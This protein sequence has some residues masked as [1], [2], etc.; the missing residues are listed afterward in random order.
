MRICA[1]APQLASALADMGHEVAAFWPSEPLFDLHGALAAR[2]FEPELIIQQESLGQ[3]VLLTGMERF[4]CPKVFWSLDT[5]LNL[6]WQRHY[7]RL[8]DGVLSPHLSI[9]EREGLAGRLADSK[10]GRL[11]DSKA[12][13][14][15][16]RMAMFAPDRP[17]RPHAERPRA[18]G[19]VG[20]LTAFRPARRWLT[21][22]LRER[23]GTE[24]A[25]DLSFEAMLDHY[26]DTRLAP[27]ESLLGEVNFRLMEAAGCGCLVLNQDVG[28]DQD[29]LLRPGVEMEVCAH[30]L[31]LR[32][33]LDH[34]LS[35]PE[36]AERMARA[37]WE[38]IQ[39]EH[40]ARHR[41]QELLSFVSGRT[42]HAQRG[43]GAQTAFW[44]AL[45]GLARAGMIAAEAEALERSLA[46]LQPGAQALAARLTLACER[47]GREAALALAATALADP[48]LGPEPEVA[49]AGSMLGVLLEDWTVA[50]GFWLLR[51]RAA[52]N[53][54]APLPEHPAA[55]CVAWA[56]ELARAGRVGSG[57]FPYD[58]AEHVP[59][60]ALECLYLAARLAPEDLDVTRRLAAMT[61]GMRGHDY[62][63]MAHLSH[64][65]LHNPRDWRT[66][67]QLG[68][69]GLKS[70]RPEEGLTEL[71]HALSNAREQGKE[72][73]FLG[74]LEACDPRGSA[75]A[76]L[77]RRP[78]RG[79]SP[80][81]A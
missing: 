7:F 27:N 19:F 32:E 31:E 50:R 47:R 62:T 57:G 14:M 25:Q 12:G 5:H 54:G 38:R 63:R 75:L 3:R 20:R 35:R 78:L 16:G 51:Q 71:R 67:L 44:L 81:G 77:L 45:A 34:Y 22:F 56:G 1:L 46:R 6:F 80:F 21:D 29:A 43:G 2:G 68:M 13:H 11:A 61:G 52:G 26:Q 59:A 58:P 8:F 41:A 65:A 37:A 55:L 72:A 24:P 9:L 70:F 69:A 64:L 60:C 48:V 23:Y 4:S 28:P 36:E 40:L 42:L 49:L 30:V 53:A 79:V 73:S 76:A 10:A 66:G 15:A 39:A 17:W 33:L 18:V 74:A